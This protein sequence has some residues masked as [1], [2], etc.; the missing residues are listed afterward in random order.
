MNLKPS[1]FGE[2]WGQRVANAGLA[3]AKLAG[4]DA[5]QP[6]ITMTQRSWVGS[7][8]NSIRSQ[9]ERNN[10]QWNADYVSKN[11]PFA[12][13]YI[14]IR[15]NYCSPQGWLPNTGDKDL[16]KEI[17]AYCD[18]VWK[19]MGINCSMWTAFS[20]S[21]D[22]EL[23]TRG[24]SALIWHRD[25]SRLRLIEVSA[26]QIG[27]LF[28]YQN[29]SEPVPG[30]MYFAGMYMDKSGIRQ[31]MK[32]YERGFNETYIN[33]E[34][35][36]ASD[37]IY[38]QDNLQ[39]GIRGVTAFHGAIESMSKAGKLLQYGL[40]AAQKQA[41]TAIVASNNMGAPLGGSGAP[42][43]YV[44]VS[45]DGRVTL[46]E[47]TYDGAVTQ[48]QYN[49]DG[50]QLVQTTAPGPELIE[51]C[52]YADEQSALSLAM[53]Y[54]FL[55][56]AE[57][58]GGAPYRGELGKAGK[59]INRIRKLHEDEFRKIV[60][61]TI[62]D[63]FD[64][65]VFG[66][67]VAAKLLNNLTQGTVV[68]P[69]DPTADSFREAK[70][71]LMYVRA[72]LDSPQRVL[73]RSRENPEEILDENK[74]WAISV[75]KAVQDANDELK[76]EGYEGN[77]TNVD[78][79]QPMEN[80]QQAATAE[81]LESGKDKVTD[82]PAQARMSAFLGDIAISKLPEGTRSAIKSALSQDDCDGYEVSKYGMVAS[83]L[84][85]MA[86]PHNLE[87]ARKNIR[88]SSN[89]NCADE[90]HANGEKHILVNNG[91]IVDGHHFLA[92][93]LKGKVSK[94]LSVIDLSPVRFQ[95]AKMVA[96]S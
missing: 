76:A 42:N 63:G 83:E 93:A 49:G 39:R 20:R 41:K 43:E 27:E 22:V 13:G 77:V 1:I 87:S 84:E 94:S 71:D 68:F 29:P 50:Y 51:G 4:Y 88:Y 19:T 62:M 95:Q 69:S 3:L 9:I 26:D 78:I 74:Q 7:N 90:V 75:S 56:N 85:K 38:F 37:V 46:I 64:R 16:N 18:E 35:F 8:P 12:I 36:P 52:R 67:G 91:R 66:R 32:V 15:R 45:E 96:T 86:D 30:M 40:D 14:K 58:E 70:E 28:F 61:V 11:V 65:G 2:K 55:V 73:G 5:G 80:M 10:M 72:G 6:K 25:E 33:P 81:Q 47:Q 60:Y 59:E 54:A 31:G 21:C 92:K 17:K 57:K 79:A 44:E 24:D 82:N 89:G 23:P 53:P 48:F 34:N